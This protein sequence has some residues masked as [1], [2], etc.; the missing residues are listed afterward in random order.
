[1]REKL[2]S[3]KV[4]FGSE[5]DLIKAAKAVV[6]FRK[7]QAGATQPAAETTPAAEPAATAQ[8]QAT[9]NTPAAA[10]QGQA[11]AEPAAEATTPTRLEIKD[12]LAIAAHM[13][14]VAQKITTFKEVVNTLTIMYNNG[15]RGAADRIT[16]HSGGQDKSISTNETINDLFKFLISESERRIEELESELLNITIC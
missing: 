1:M 7:K 4:E 10:A 6:E 3:A 8:K 14:G 13:L 11:A 5:R 15:V 12:K 2:K 9:A 16:I